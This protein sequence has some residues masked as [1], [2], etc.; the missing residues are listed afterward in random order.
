MVMYCIL[1]AGNFAGSDWVAAP[2]GA[3]E[4]KK[5]AGN[6]K[7]WITAYRLTHPSFFNFCSFPLLTPFSFSSLSSVFYPLHAFTMASQQNGASNGATSND[8]TVK[9]GLAQMLKGGVIM[10]VVN[11]EQVRWSCSYLAVAYSNP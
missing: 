6:C 8:F 3:G 11:A 1:P 2:R 4:Q 10:D 9:A 5:S 7:V